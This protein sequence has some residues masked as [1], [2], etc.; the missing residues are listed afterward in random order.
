M[1]KRLDVYTLKL[2]LVYARL[3]ERLP[4]IEEEQLAA[5]MLVTNYAAR[6]VKR[7]ID[8]RQAG[9]N[10]AKDAEARIFAAIRNTKHPPIKRHTQQSLS[11][12]MS[13]REFNQGFDA[14]LKSE[15]IDAQ[16]VARKRTLV[17]VAE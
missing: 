13:A 1:T 12:Y 2:G 16:E 8:Q 5:A 9:S 7:L 15:R 3:E 17:W 14:L 10:P 6:A 4:N 11:K